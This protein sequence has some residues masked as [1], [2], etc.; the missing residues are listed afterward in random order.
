VLFG[1]GVQILS[2]WLLFLLSSSPSRGESEKFSAMKD[3]GQCPLVLLAEI[4]WKQVKELRT[5]GRVLGR[6]LLNVCRRGTQ[7]STG[8]ELWGGGGSMRQGVR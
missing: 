6:R 4:G 2:E 5:E 7:L 8:A 1:Y 3:P